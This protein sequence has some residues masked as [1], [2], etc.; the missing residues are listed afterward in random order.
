MK[1]INY[2][3]MLLEA[4]RFEG[5][6]DLLEEL[7]QSDPGNKDILYNLGMC[8]TELGKP[9]KAVKTLS[10]CTRYYPH[11]ANAHVAA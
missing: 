9:E 10:E 3:F 11:Y 7:L 2:A 8:Y 4:K 1:D 6:R 5:A